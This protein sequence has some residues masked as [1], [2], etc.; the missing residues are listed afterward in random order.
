[1]AAKE[2]RFG[3]EARE[4]AKKLDLLKKRLPQKALRSVRHAPK[5][6]DLSA[7]TRNMTFLVCRIRGFAAIVHSFASDP[8]GLSRLVRPLFIFWASNQCTSSNRNRSWY[9]FLIAKIADQSN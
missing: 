3:G 4:R 6:L 7:E 2:V 9:L 8:E 5:L 1:M